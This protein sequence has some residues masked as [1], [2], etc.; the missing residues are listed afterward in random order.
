MC[1]LFKLLISWLAKKKKKVVNFWSIFSDAKKIYGF[2]WSS[3]NEIVWKV[4]LFDQETKQ[5]GMNYGVL[6]EYPSYAQE[7]SS[8]AQK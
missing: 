8:Y 7:Y 2:W 6:Q 3:P 5:Q 4:P 1:M